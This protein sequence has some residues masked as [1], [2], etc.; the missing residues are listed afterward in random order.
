MKEEIDRA[1]EE[2]NKG[3]VILYPTDT[4]WGIGCDATNEEAIKKI[5]SIKQRSESK[6]LITIVSSDAMLQRFISE[7]PEL[8]WDIMDLATKPTTIIYS[9][10]TGLARNAIAD[11]NTVGVRVVREGFANKLIHKFNKPII[12]TSANISNS[13]SPISFDT[14][15][16][17]I[18]K[19]VDYT[20]GAQFES[21]NSEPSS[22]LKIAMNGEI[23]IL[24]K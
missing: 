3:G 22:I 5:Y 10:P 14:I 20:V 17:H 8:A 23:E 1:I 24:R 7:V 4:I 16:E 11:D 12:S 2:L 13:P 9:N 6:S 15:N 19:A 18:K 21:N